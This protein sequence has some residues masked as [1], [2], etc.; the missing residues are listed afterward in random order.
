MKTK[1]FTRSNLI[2]VLLISLI[3]LLLVQANNLQAA[4]GEA[5][6]QPTAGLHQDPDSDDGSLEQ[7]QA[8]LNLAEGDPT[9]F[10]PLT[11]WTDEFSDASGWHSHESYWSTIQFPDLNNDNMADVCG[12][13]SSGIFCALST[14]SD[15]TGAK[16]WND[17]FPDGNAQI[18]LKNDPSIWG[19]I[20]FADV[21]GS[22]LNDL[23]GRDNLGMVCFENMGSEFDTLIYSDGSNSFRNANGWHTH[24]SYWGTIQMPNVNGGDGLADIC[25]R[26]VD[27]I[28]C[29]LATGNTEFREGFGQVT[30]WIDNYTDAFGWNTHE[31]Y[32]GTI[33]FPDID[34]DGRAD[35]CGRG[36]NGILCARS[37]RRSFN[38]L[39]F[40][41]NSFSDRN[42]WKNHESY[43]GTIRF[44]D[45]NGDDKAD[46]CG[47]GS[48]G[49]I[50]SLSNGETFT[51]AKT[52]TF[53]FSDSAGWKSDESYW[54]TIQFP[55]VN[56]DGLDDVCGRD[57][58]GIMCEL[59]NGSEF[60]SSVVWI[61]DFSDDEGW[62]TAEAYWGTIRFPDVNGDGWADV[63][64]RGPDG[65]VCA[66]AATNNQPVAVDDTYQ[67]TPDA[68]LT[69]EAADGVLSND[70]DA[71]GEVLTVSLDQTVTHGTLAIDLD[72]S[73]TYTPNPGFSGVDHF[74]YYPLDTSFAASEV[75]AQ[76]TIEVNVAPTPDPTPNPTPNP[77]DGDFTVFL[78]L[79]VK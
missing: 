52:W 62:N 37:T 77:G 1:T 34:G 51:Q 35:V 40:W 9:R 13:S 59:S 24:E 49:I 44:P 72:G 18:D 42:G 8:K 19:T 39:A 14:G 57:S 7:K 25:G 26:D 20:Q 53:N 31:S 21:N 46:V 58:L 60:L 3:L 45:V 64:G 22:G 41:D 50:C 17:N 5:S 74:Y 6:D 68:V 32:W 36:G 56:G 61:F 23:C 30:T 55:D 66:L 54:G 69:I 38:R 70:L 43:W 29:T 76:V 63:C 11:T 65:I 33:Q 15:F 4:G 28:V 78:P 16:I 75:P 67:V 10:Y 79:V 27:G 48:S 47:R 2:K 12:R 73:F 71:D